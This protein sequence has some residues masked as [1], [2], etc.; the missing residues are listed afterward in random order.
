MKNKV[1]KIQVDTNA[2]G[3]VATLDMKKNFGSA[4]SEVFREGR[5]VQEALGALIL[6]TQ[7]EYEISIVFSN[8]VQHCLAE[9]SLRRAMDG[10][11]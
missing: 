5:T 7:D 8:R 9:D 2:R 10:N 4:L 11:E 3:F 6:A 1:I